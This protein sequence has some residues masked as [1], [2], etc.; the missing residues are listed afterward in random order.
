MKYE[1]QRQIHKYRVMAVPSG[2]R[3]AADVSSSDMR[4]VTVL[5][6]RQ[7]GS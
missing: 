2:G 5:E 4:V 1:A 6:G 3:S 7:I